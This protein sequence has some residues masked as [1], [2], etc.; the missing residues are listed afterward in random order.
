[1]N[2]TSKKIISL[3]IILSLF[4]VNCEILYLTPTPKINK[5][6]RQKDKQKQIIIS[7]SA[8]HAIKP[9]TRIIVILWSGDQVEGKFVELVNVPTEEYAASYAKCREQLKDKIVLPELEETVTVVATNGLQYSLEFL[10]FDYGCILTRF[11]VMGKTRTAREDLRLIKNIVDSR[12]NSIG[13]EEVRKLIFERKIP[14]LSSGTFIIK[15]TAG[16]IQIAWE[17]IEQIQKKKK[18]TLAYIVPL[19]LGVVV[20][21]VIIVVGEIKKDLE[22]LER[23]GCVMGSVTR[24]SPM[25]AYMNTLR[26][27]RDNYLLTNKLGREFVDLYYEYSPYVSNIIAKHKVLKIVVRTKLIPLI[28]FC[29]SMVHLGPIMTGALLIFI[30]MLPFFLAMYHR[31]K[32]RQVR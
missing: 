24:N 30:F 8:W 4:T 26:D 7:P 19:V 22:E 23:S 11:E 2:P 31:K 12:G 1:M 10:G 25:N 17:D 21:G 18:N 27:F 9:G 14:L 6:P 13:K 20:A 3:F 5:K 16:R 15:S 32:I 29:Y 28:A